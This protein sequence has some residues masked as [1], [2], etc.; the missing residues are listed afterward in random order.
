[1]TKK[2]LLAK[3]KP[4]P[5]YTQIAK[6]AFEL[7]FELGKKEN[8]TEEFINNKIELKKV[9]AELKS[10]WNTLEDPEKCGELLSGM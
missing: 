5:T 9:K 8:Q 7:G 1:M 3:Y 4:Y 10:L 6:E 2:D